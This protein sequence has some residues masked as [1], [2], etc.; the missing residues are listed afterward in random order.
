MDFQQALAFGIA[1]VAAGYLLRR[2]L[3][4]LRSGSGGCGSCSGCPE[5]M[6]LSTEKLPVRKQLYSIG[7]LERD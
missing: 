5:N 2:S 4:S 1:V 3:L 7:D 6:S